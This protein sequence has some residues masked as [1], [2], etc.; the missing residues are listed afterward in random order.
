MGFRHGGAICESEDAVRLESGLPSMAFTR[1][2]N[3]DRTFKVILYKYIFTSLHDVNLETAVPQVTRYGKA[4]NIEECAC[5][6]EYTGTSCE[7]SLQ[8]HTASYCKDGFLS[9]FNPIQTRGNLPARTF[10]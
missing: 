7:V 8:A 10:F 1:M 5:P 9:L 4:K 6:P 3:V 2:K